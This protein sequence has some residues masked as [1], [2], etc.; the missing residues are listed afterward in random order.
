MKFKSRETGIELLRIL[1]M[2]MVISLHYLG[3]GGA[4]GA[5]GSYTK[6]QVV[7]EVLECFCLVAVNVYV[8]ISG[9]FLVDSRFRFTKVIKLWFQIFFYS[10][11][12]FIVMYLL[13]LVPEMYNEK[14]FFLEAFMPLTTQHYWFATIY[15]AMYL[16]SPFMALLARSLNKTQLRTLVIILL[17]LFSRVWKIVLPQSYP[18]DDRGY[19]IL[20][21]VTLFF[22]AAYLKLYCSDI[23]GSLKFFAGYVIF[24]LINVGSIFAI[25]TISEI[26]GRFSNLIECFIEYNGPFTYLASISLFLCFK[27]IKINNTNVSKIIVFISGGTF[28]VY[29]LHEHFL[30]R[31][32]WNDL[33][34]VR[35]YATGR[36]FVLHYLIVIFLV[37]I[38]GVA[39][40]KVREIIFR[41]LAKIPAVIKL[42][43][44]VSKVDYFFEGRTN[45]RIQEN[46]K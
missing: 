25:G 8:I 35:D 12:I 13:N 36:Y 5:Y 46:G 14:Y 32:L 34:H 44:V 30:L 39:V 37:L 11:G 22:S 9:Y 38:I 19:G 6:N 24:S 4:L 21:F 27:N 31:G 45:S 42:S 16:L 26:T 41:M 2:L 7:A 43:D 15:F 1:A 29:L 23:K 18:I 10:A 40:D 28:G 20:W 3:K 33:W 17:L